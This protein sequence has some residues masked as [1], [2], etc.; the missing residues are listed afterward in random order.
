MDALTNQPIGLCKNAAELGQP[1]ND[2]V[3][4]LACNEK[5]VPYMSVTLQSILENSDPQREYDII[6]LTSD[7]SPANMELLH[8]QASCKPNVRVGFLDAM[9]AAGN[10]TLPCHGHFACET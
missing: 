6:V 5:F 10:A 4:L 7:I 8:W 3:V 9:A 1:M 2:V